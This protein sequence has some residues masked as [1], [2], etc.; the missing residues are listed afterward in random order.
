MTIMSK[1]DH[2]IIEIFICTA[3]MPASIKNLCSLQCYSHSFIESQLKVVPGLKSG[4]QSPKTK[5][6]MPSNQQYCK[7]MQFLSDS[8]YLNGE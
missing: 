6:C 4:K 2:G 8:T 7:S 1:V 3:A 5:V